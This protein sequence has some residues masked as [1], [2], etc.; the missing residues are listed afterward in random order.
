MEQNQNSLRPEASTDERASPFLLAGRAAPDDPRAFEPVPLRYRTDGWTPERQR[1][2]LEALADTGVI[3]DAAARVGITEQSVAR[4]RRRPEAR[5]FDI[6]CRAA[7][8]M[9][10]R[11]RIVETAFR[12]AVE[13]TVKGHYYHGELKSEERVYDN[14]LLTYLVG[15]FG[16]LAEPDPQSLEAERNWPAWLDDL[17]REEPIHSFEQ[18]PGEILCTRYPFWEEDGTCWTDFPPPDG[19]EGREEGSWGRSDY[20]RTLSEAEWAVVEAGDAHTEARR[21]ARAR[22]ERD[23]CFGFSGNRDFSFKEAEPSEPSEPFADPAGAC[24][25]CHGIERAAPEPSGPFP[26]NSASED[27]RTTS[28]AFGE[29]QAARSPPKERNGDPPRPPHRPLRRLAAVERAL[30]AAA[31]ARAPV[32]VNVRQRLSRPRTSHQGESP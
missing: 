6:G 20:R 1:A 30:A 15:K 18:E 26:L 8:R 27:G 32:D 22:A 25:P 13:G 24:E 4:L 3:R 17:E 28:A 14:R 19:F 29:P 7:Q 16:H 10:V 31:D 9:G 21:L 5:A 11:N 12:R 2:F 23:A